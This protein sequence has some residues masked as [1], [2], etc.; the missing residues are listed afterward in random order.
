MWKSPKQMGLLEF[1]ADTELS[2][3]FKTRLNGCARQPLGSV[4]F[5]PL[6]SL[7]T[8]CL[9]C[10]LFLFQVPSCSYVIRNDQH[11]CLCGLDKHKR[12][13]PINVALDLSSLGM[14]PVEYIKRIRANKARPCRRPQC[15]PR[16]FLTHTVDGRSPAPL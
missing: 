2:E 8:P 12:R 9:I 10:R 4:S 1:M 11:M 13:R 3:A 15:A 14:E 7:C 6:Y 16:L 5:A